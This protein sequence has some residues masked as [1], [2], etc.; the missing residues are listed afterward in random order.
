MKTMGKICLGFFF[1]FIALAIAGIIVL[2][3]SGSLQNICRQFVAF[4]E[5][6]GNY[7]F[8]VDWDFEEH[9]NFSETKA[10]T[11]DGIRVITIN[12]DASQV[13]ISQSADADKV[14]VDYKSGSK[15][16]GSYNE[17]KTGEQGGALFI[18][19]TAEKGWPRIGNHAPTSRLKIVIPQGYQGD[20]SLET[21]VGKIRLSAMDLKE[22]AL[23]FDLD[24]GTL[25]LDGV[26]AKNLTLDADA[27]TINLSSVAFS[28]AAEV[29]LDAGAIK[30]EG[31]T[32]ASLKL[33]SDAAAIT[34]NGLSAPLQARGSV[35]ALRFS[36][37]EITGDISIKSDL[38]S[39]DLT[40]PKGA[41]V[42]LETPQRVSVNDQIS[43]N[44]DAPRTMKDAKYT[45]DIQGNLGS[46]SLYE[47]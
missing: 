38:S 9:V 30:S 15:W 11:I 39:V 7:F 40:I 4:A 1:G 18:E 12:A 42:R 37:Q 13:D 16:G 35:G 24:A 23:S 33:D 14:S 45:I 34:L 17:L 26:K 25:D 31:F 19:A 44:G 10:F 28:G 20:L 21:T 32:A 41:P 27:A 22:G 3:S 36:F 6:H 47:N 46:L 2:S 29:T 8:E 43:W 5:S